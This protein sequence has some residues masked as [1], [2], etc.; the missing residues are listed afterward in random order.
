MRLVER[1]LG[2]EIEIKENVVSVIVLEDVASRLSIIEELYSQ[3]SGKDGNWIL[4]ENEKSFELCKKSE[5]ILEPFSLELNNKKVKTKMYQ[6]L[7][8]IAQ[9]FCFEQGLE[10]HSHICNYLECLLGRMPYPIKYDEEWNILELF[11][12][13]GVE[14]AEESDSLCEKL[15]HYLKLIN[16]VSGVNIFIILNIKQYL[17][18]KQLFELYKLAMYSKIQLVLM[19]FNMSNN[20]LDC[21]ETYILDKDRCIITC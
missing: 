10:L 1:E 21:E 3:V 11:K 5:M 17:T 19:E 12:A 16:Q 20:I 7:K 6:D 14:L 2:L 13:Y 8:T 9:D 15:F 4:V 18:E